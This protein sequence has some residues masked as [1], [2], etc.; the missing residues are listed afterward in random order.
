MTDREEQFVNRKSK[1][2]DTNPI[3]NHPSSIINSNAFTLIELLVVIAVLVMLMAL[4]VPALSR[5]RKQAQTVA[6]Q[7]GIHGWALMFAAYQND[8]DGRF[9]DSRYWVWDDETG[10]RESIQIPW[11][12]QI[13]VYSGLDLREAMLCPAASKLLPAG[14][15][16]DRGS[17]VAGGTTSMAWHYERLWDGVLP[18]DRTHPQYDGSYAT[19][20]H[21]SY[22]GQVR[23]VK[24]SALP[25][26][27]DS[28]DCYAGLTWA[29]ADEP[30]PYEDAPLIG[31]SYYYAADLTIDR[32]QGGI[33][34]M[35]LDGAIRKVGIKEIWTL[36]WHAEYDTAGPWTKAGGA[37]PDDWPEWM[38]RFKD[39]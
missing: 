33:N 16:R 25:A 31:S 1:H 8:N 30:P 7:S 29:A 27:F 26:F 32:H 34:I 14:T 36:R 21:L 39:Y 17:C 4:L 15:W 13:E 3:I 37:T 22:T 23:K 24:P 6:C 12:C 2:A 5:A 35:F 38:R 11:P 9:V 19:N 10:Q 18:A 28:R 20:G